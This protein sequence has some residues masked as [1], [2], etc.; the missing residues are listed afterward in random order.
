[1]LSPNE[2]NREASI[3]IRS[4][5]KKKAWLEQ[6]KYTKTGNLRLHAQSIS[7]WVVINAKTKS[8][9]K[10]QSV[11]AEVVE[12]MK[13]KGWLVPDPTGALII[14]SLV[15]SDQQKTK[16][17]KQLKGPSFVGQHQLQKPA[18]IKD[19]EQRTIFTT[20]N[21]TECPLGWMRA[22]K[23]KAGNPLLDD[24]QFE[25]G[26]RIRADFTM[27]QLSPRVT[28]SWD[29]S[30]GSGASGGRHGGDVL[31]VSEKVVAAK[32]R[33]FNALD[34]LGPEMS[35]IVLEVCCLMSGLEA[36]ERALGWPRRS[37]KLVLAIALS[38]LS[39]HYG[40]VAPDSQQVRKNAI[41]HWGKQGYQPQVPLAKTT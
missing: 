4:L 35:S 5:V 7:K 3:V 13:S 8:S 34:V 18:V 25:A 6:R 37:A 17:N 31:E 28:A 24:F 16:P 11:E 41:R 30:G 33:L 32:Q 19:Q 22:R 15:T 40:L 36:A 9:A 26:E 39:I 12:M 2:L 23:D 27:A 20:R 14:S 21:E 38:K 29:F 10:L 1:M